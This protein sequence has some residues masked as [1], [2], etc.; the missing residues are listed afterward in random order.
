MILV[1]GA[2]GK[3]GRQAVVQLLDAGVSV[4]A[5]VR[6]PETAALPAGVEVVRG[7]LTDAASVEA[8]VRGVD[9]VFLVWP[10]TTADAAPAVIAAAEKHA[11]R[12][13][14]LSAFGVPDDDT[15][16][17]E[18][19][20][21]G[22][23]TAIE[24]AIRATDLEWT[25]LRAGGFAANTLGWADQVRQHGAVRAAHAK[26]TRSLIHEADIAAVAVRALTTDELLGATPHLTGPEALT[27]EE[28]VRAI[29]E[30]L[31][32]DVVFE[33]LGEEAAAAELEAQGIPSFYALAIVQAH[34][35]M[36]DEP[37]TASPAVAE[38]TGRARTYREWVADHAA[39]FS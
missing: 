17:A 12:I 16:E 10:L 6:N 23:H 20:I 1:T 13:V 37:E 21:I 35:Q 9:A 19:G 38:I 11:R 27:Q 15:V 26:A 30:V 5:L 31:G 39:D 29:G 7:D 2:T 22:F 28:Q 4:R 24:R 32:K 8:A 3:V 34:G 36:V 18:E 25:M 33:E 14:Y